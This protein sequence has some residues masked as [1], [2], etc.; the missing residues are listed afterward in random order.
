M[1]KID[2]TNP[3]FDFEPDELSAIIKFYEE[4]GFKWIKKDSYVKTPRGNLLTKEGVEK[5]LSEKLIVGNRNQ[6]DALRV[7][8]F[9]KMNWASFGMA[10]SGLPFIYNPSPKELKAF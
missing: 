5:I 3:Y 10:A 4:A 6:V 7:A 1:N 9:F 2:W 8:E